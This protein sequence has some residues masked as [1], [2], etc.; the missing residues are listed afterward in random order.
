[1]K[2]FLRPPKTPFSLSDSCTFLI[3]ACFFLSGVS[4]ATPS[5]TLSKKNGPPT[6]KILVSGCGFES[7]VGV[8]IF[9]DTKDEALVVTNSKG[10]FHNAKA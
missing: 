8:D 6:T 7:N 3:V 5:I 1:M 4:G 10:E 9:F 2:P